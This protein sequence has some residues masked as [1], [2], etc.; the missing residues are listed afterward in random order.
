MR[1]KTKMAPKNLFLTMDEAGAKQLIANELNSILGNNITSTAL[2]RRRVDPGELIINVHMT[3]R[4]GA[5]LTALLVLG[6]EWGSDRYYEQL[7][8]A[9]ADKR[10]GLSD[11]I[12]E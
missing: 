9:Q 11:D 6:H 4:I 3:D 1:R 2:K 10:H 12:P 7:K 8:R 5:I